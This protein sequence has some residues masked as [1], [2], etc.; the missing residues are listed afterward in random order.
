MVD[1]RG[2]FFYMFCFTWNGALSWLLEW[3]RK[4]TPEWDECLDHPRRDSITSF[5]FV[6]IKLTKLLCSWCW[7]N[8]SSE[9]YV[10]RWIVGLWE[11]EGR[12]RESQCRVRAHLCHWRD[13]WQKKGKTFNVREFKNANGISLIFFCQMS[14]LDWIWN[15]YKFRFQS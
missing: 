14:P 1:M 5:S 2:W 11:G 3:L 10:I 15:I 12:P 4:V 8:L 7:L 6:Q 13:G 9:C